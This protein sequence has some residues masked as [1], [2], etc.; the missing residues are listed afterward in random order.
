MLFGIGLILVVVCVCVFLLCG[1]MCLVG[2]GCLVVVFFVV[3]VVFWV[4]VFGVDIS[5]VVDK[6]LM[7]VVIR[8]FFMELEFFDN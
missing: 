3:V 8:S 7:V 6:V 1:M 5:I 2:V 4:N